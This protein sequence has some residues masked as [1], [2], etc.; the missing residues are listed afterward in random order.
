MQY[1]TSR[2]L[3]VHKTTLFDFWEA[4]DVT[5]WMIPAMASQLTKQQSAK[6]TLTCSI[7]VSIVNSTLNSEPLDNNVRS[8]KCYVTK[9]LQESTWKIQNVYKGTLYHI[10]IRKV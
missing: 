9:Q 10:V 2:C 8:N 1:Y 3:F 7:K 5:I 4:W 6:K